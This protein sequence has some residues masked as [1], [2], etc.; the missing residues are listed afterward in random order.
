MFAERKAFDI[1]ALAADVTKPHG[2][3]MGRANRKDL[4]HHDP[5]EFPHLPGTLL[6]SRE[7]R[8]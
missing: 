1:D 3:C 8:M 5:L 2:I 6:Q 4:C 7:A